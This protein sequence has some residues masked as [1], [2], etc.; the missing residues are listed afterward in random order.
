MA[1]ALL[2][3][4]IFTTGLAGC[5]MPP[6]TAD[7][8]VSAQ[9]ATLAPAP[10]RPWADDG[11]AV[12]EPAGAGGTS[13]HVGDAGTPEPAGDAGRSMRTDDIEVPGRDDGAGS[14]PRPVGADDP[15]LR[16]LIAE[17]LRNNDDVEAARARLDVARMERGLAEQRRWPTPG[18]AIQQ[19]ERAGGGER[20]G[21]ER[22]SQTSASLTLAQP[23]DIGGELSRR[24]QAA[25]AQTVALEFA[26]EDVR[27]RLVA[28][29]SSAYWRIAYLDRE[30]ALR[31]AA[32]RDA[33]RLASL[34]E[35][36]HR[37]GEVSGDDVARAAR[38]VAAQRGAC[39]VT[40]GEQA[41]ARHA[42]RRLLAVADPAAV[43]LR[44]R[45]TLPEVDR[46]PAI[47]PG[48]PAHLLSRRPDLRAQEWRLREAARLVDATH[49]SF[50][51]RMTL[52]GSLGTASDS[53]SDWLRHPIATL[54]AELSFPVLEWRARPWRIGAADA[55]ARLALNAFARTLHQALREVEDGLSGRRRHLA[56]R[57]AMQTRLA[58]AA[59]EADLAC[60]RY[61][62]GETDITP[63]LERRAARRDAEAT[64]LRLRYDLAVNA[65]MLQQALGGALIPIKETV[66][67]G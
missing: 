13:G 48:L 2:S 32:L 34:V 33:L 52:T 16:A 36:R 39:A 28:E 43:M 59:R 14:P 65:V 35:T 7:E 27:R 50:Y 51:P 54:M 22:F 24:A 5:A 15:V 18:F 60:A 10:L 6:H 37:L 46:L 9:L 67:P 63:W 25:H 8:R 49:A 55:R 53:L 41:S 30:A 40:A 45:P 47:D 56:E 17:A 58:A 29:V 26:R 12:P 19:R 66:D 57:A 64:L 1:R 61:R 20:G 44:D 21:G 4:T 38:Q 42:L 23:L 11:P 3:L 62:A 31:E